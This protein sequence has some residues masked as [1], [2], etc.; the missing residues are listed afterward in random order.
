[1]KLSAL[2]VA[3]FFAFVAQTLA[4]AL[5]QAPPIIACTTTT[6]YCRSSM[7]SSVHALISHWFLKVA[8]HV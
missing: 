3:V 8:V 5:P 7:N 1:M 4:E 2:P 6:F